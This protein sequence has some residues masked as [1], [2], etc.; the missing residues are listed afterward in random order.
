MPSGGSISS[1][2]PS[3]STTTTASTSTTSIPAH[4]HLHRRQLRLHRRR[5]A[6]RLPHEARSQ[7]QRRPQVRAPH[8]RPLRPAHHLV[9]HMHDALPHQRLARHRTLLPRHRRP[10]GLVREPLLH[11]HRHVPLNRR[12]HGRRPRRSRRS[13]WREPFHLARLALPLAPP[14]AHLRPRCL[15]L[16][17]GARIFQ[18][19]VPRLGVSQTA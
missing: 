3:S 5:M 8:L 19:L 12:H 13:G 1:I 7:R 4:R 17:D 11:P 18:L 15:R 2:S 10:S 9:P 6:L 16:R 14:D